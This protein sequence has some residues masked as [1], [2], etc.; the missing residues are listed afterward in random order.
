MRALT[1]SELLAV[2]EQGLAL[3]PLQRGLSL[4]ATACPEAPPEALAE[5]SIGQRDARLLTLREWTFGPQLAS[6]ATCPAC[7]ERLELA[8]EVDDVRVEPA[9]MP[10]EALS[11]SVGG[12]EVRFRLPNSRDLA[13]LAG[14]EGQGGVQ[15]PANARRRLV[16]RC[17]LD[18]GDEAAVDRWPAE[19]LDAVEER[20]AEADPQADVGLALQCPE[21]QHPWQAAFDI[22]SF[23]WH[24]IE[25]WAPRIL[26]QVHTLASAYGWREADILNMSASRR[27]MYI[28]MVTG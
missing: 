15:G 4:L 3:S 20:M 17:L 9:E 12:R 2:W 13:S 1:T 27:Q 6:L 5:L 21:C 28:D 11:L 25:A 24:E 19:V 26:Y 23:F 14:P 16:E 8:F 7:G 10:A 18:G 22:V